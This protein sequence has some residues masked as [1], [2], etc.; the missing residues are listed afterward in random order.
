MIVHGSHGA[1]GCH[2]LPE[3]V[4]EQY[5]GNNAPAETIPRVKNHHWDWLDAIRPA[6]RPDPI[7]TT[8]AA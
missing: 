5:S 1:G 8:A 4:R 3:K 2:L 6:A 7:S